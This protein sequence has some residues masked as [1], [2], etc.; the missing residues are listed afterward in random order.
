[1]TTHCAACGRQLKRNP[2]PTH[3]H[4][5]EILG[6]GFTEEAA[7]RNAWSRMLADAMAKEG[8]K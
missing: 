5:S 4:D 7:W 8:G 2:G 1:M 3:Y 6:T